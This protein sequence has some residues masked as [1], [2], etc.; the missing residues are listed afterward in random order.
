MS[1]DVNRNYIDV[2]HINEFVGSLVRNTFLV[3][4]CVIYATLTLEMVSGGEAPT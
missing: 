2:D 3:C 4:Y 1:E